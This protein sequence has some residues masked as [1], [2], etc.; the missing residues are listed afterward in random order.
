M[1]S[2]TSG[3]SW[4]CE[5]C[6]F[7]NDNATL[8]RCAMCETRRHLP[9]P[10]PATHP[11]PAAPHAV[12][13][14]ATLTPVRAAA[15]SD[16]APPAARATAPA[17]STTA[18]TTANPPAHPTP[19][20]VGGLRYTSAAYVGPPKTVDAAASVMTARA[21][22]SIT[23]AAATQGGGPQSPSAPALPPTAMASGGL[24]A[25]VNLHQWMSQAADAD[26]RASYTLFQQGRYEEASTLAEVPVCAWLRRGYELA[27]SR[28]R[29]VDEE[30]E[31]AILSRDAA[32][33][34]RRVIDDR[35]AF[36]S[37]I[38]DL[39]NI[40]STPFL[41]ERR[42]PQ[43]KYLLEEAAAATAVPTTTPAMTS[44]RILRRLV[45]ASPPAT[46]TAPPVGGW[47]DSVLLAAPPH[48]VSRMLDFIAE[49]DKVS[50]IAEHRCRGQATSI[51][52]KLLV[53][54]LVDLCRFVLAMCCC[55]I[56]LDG[57]SD[58]SQ[59][60]GNS[61]PQPLGSPAGGQSDTSKSPWRRLLKRNCATLRADP[62]T[63]KTYLRAM[64]HAAIVCRSVR[65]HKV[66]VE[67]QAA[68]S[69]LTAELQSV[70]DE[71]FTAAGGDEFAL[72]AVDRRKPTASTSCC[73]CGLRV[74][75]GSADAALFSQSRLGWPMS[76]SEGNDLRDE[77]EEEGAVTE[78]LCYAPALRLLECY[79]SSSSHVEGSS[80]AN[81]GGI[82]PAPT[83]RLVPFQV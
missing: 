9:P 16:A 61:P 43:L 22:V 66:S 8:T 65:Q 59:R 4:T 46:L 20:A 18:R 71:L 51:F 67:V 17:A 58:A 42:S 74:D 53:G 68:T 73:L 76:A 34:L 12:R 56:E 48:D 38:T 49:C 13:G 2:M 11:L 44:R 36:A 7:I 75:P 23:T 78:R 79:S 52:E 35:A 41:E 54:C 33:G 69:V 14:F 80:E 10:L 64:Q 60:R 26:V 28:H 31:L 5:A 19:A 70:L 27:L 37:F 62:L 25:A 55:T 3:A 39:P 32:R 1:T 24:V 21:T 15:V 6:T 45:V 47:D 77:E 57:G 82:R 30:L 83:D 29:L 81:G 63:S 40:T 72:P 50:L